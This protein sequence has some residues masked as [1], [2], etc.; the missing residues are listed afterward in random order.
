MLERAKREPKL[1]TVVRLAASL[2]ITLTQLLHGISDRS[3]IP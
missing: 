3:L 1:A 2:D